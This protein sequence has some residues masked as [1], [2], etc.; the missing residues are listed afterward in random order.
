MTPGE[1][2]EAALA[3]QDRIRVLVVEDEAEMRGALREVMEMN[4]MA[5]DTASDGM[6]A[7]SRVFNTAYDV[8]V[9]DIRLPGMSGIAM[10][11]SLGLRARWPR[12]ILITA[13][14]S[15]EI[16]AEA[17]AAGAFEVVAKPLNLVHL[18]QRVRLAAGRGAKETVPRA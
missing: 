10:A 16:V 9:S 12:I 3:A 4:N 5:V 2:S 8:V 6:A 13:Y 17:E 15:P 7:T 14:P 18:A 1:T 11:R